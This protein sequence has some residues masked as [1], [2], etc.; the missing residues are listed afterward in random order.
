MMLN[1]KDLQ[2]IN[3]KKKKK[4]QELSDIV[5]FECEDCTLFR[6]FSNSIILF[7]H[8]LDSQ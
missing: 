6:H 2:N 4:K 7:I 3:R 1:E 8:N 5:H